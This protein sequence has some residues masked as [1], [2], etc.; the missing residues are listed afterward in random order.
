MKGDDKILKLRLVQLPYF[1][2]LIVKRKMLTEAPR[3]KLVLFCRDVRPAVLGQGKLGSILY[4]DCTL[5]LQLS[6]KAAT[7][8]KH[9]TNNI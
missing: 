5:L 9:E 8:F 2:M 6:C 1:K 3:L 4:S 7:N